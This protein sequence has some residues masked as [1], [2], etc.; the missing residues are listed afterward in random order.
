MMTEDYPDHQ[1][2]RE[3][4]PRYEGEGP[5]ALWHFSDNDSLRMFVP[6]VSTKPGAPRLV[7]AVDSRHAPMFWFPRSCPRGCIWP[8][9]TTTEK[10]REGFF[11]QSAANRIHVMEADWLQRMRDCRLYAYRLPA[12]T[13][14]PDDVV[15]G[16]WISDRP[17]EAIERVVIDDLLGRHAAAGIELRITP[18]IWPL[19]ERVIE[20]T[21]EFNGSKG[22]PSR[23]TAG[24]RGAPGG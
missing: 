2:V 1:L 19:W 17:V 20:S 23:V 6:R 15:G 13:F 9:S 22:L 7:W 8:D 4:A 18:R 21:V 12:K 5:H 24:S 10:D 14:R 16:F 11:G 3:P